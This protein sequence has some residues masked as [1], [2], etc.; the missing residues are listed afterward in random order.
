MR[1]IST[2]ELPIINKL[3]NQAEGKEDF[4]LGEDDIEDT[5]EAKIRR[6]STMS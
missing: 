4:E 3:I 1:E 5:P 2:W 6:L